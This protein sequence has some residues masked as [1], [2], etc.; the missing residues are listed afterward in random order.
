[1][2]TKQHVKARGYTVWGR[3]GT[4]AEFEIVELAEYVGDR[5]ELANVCAADVVGS[6]RFRYAWVCP[7]GVHPDRD[8][9]VSMV[10]R[11]ADGGLFRLTALP[12]RFPGL[13]L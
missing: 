10:G 7:L 5:L 9:W 6:G 8:K 2:A 3:V 12:K 4:A 13:D 11:W 1:M